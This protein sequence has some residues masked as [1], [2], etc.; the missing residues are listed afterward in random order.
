MDYRAH[1]TTIIENTDNIFGEYLGRLYHLGFQIF[2]IFHSG[3]TGGL[4]SIMPNKKSYSSG[5]TMIILNQDNNFI[6]TEDR[7]LYELFGNQYT[8]VTTQI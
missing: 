3:F 4:L 5:L 7:V 6:Y 8:G 1:I 2:Y